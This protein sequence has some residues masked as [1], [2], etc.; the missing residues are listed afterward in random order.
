[1]QSVRVKFYEWSFVGLRKFFKNFTL[2]EGELVIYFL[3]NLGCYSTNNYQISPLMQDKT[4]M[5]RPVLLLH[6]VL[7]QYIQF[8][9]GKS[10]VDLLRV[11]S[12]Y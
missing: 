5:L 7:I 1:M 6:D 4:K 8:Q 12:L 3:Q 10:G 2:D 11:S 9:S